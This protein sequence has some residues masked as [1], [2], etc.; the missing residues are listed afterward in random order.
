MMARAL[1]GLLLLPAMLVAGPVETSTA[2]GPAV[3]AADMRFTP[4]IMTIAVGQ[5]V[6]W[7]FPDAVAHTSTSDQGFWDSDTQSD[8]ST[9][10]RTFPSAGTF[11]Y[12]SSHHRE[13]TGKIRVP[14]TRTGSTADGWTLTW[15]TTSA[16]R[17]FDVQVRKG[18]KPWRV[19]WNRT[20]SV[21]GSFE[22]K[23]TWSVRVRTHQGSSTSGWSPVVTV[24]T[25]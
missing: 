18:K 2:S 21:G 15:A 13:M 8:G 12:H 20:A 5:S 24:T 25:R 14:V 7:G 11:P 23:G 17:T 3:S 16:T 1:V 6:I 10:S 4:A 19:Q 22:R 9:F